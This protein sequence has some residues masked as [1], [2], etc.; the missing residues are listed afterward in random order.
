VLR[1]VV[2]PVCGCGDIFGDLA[3]G[4]FLDAV[5]EFVEVFGGGGNEGGGMF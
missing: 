2:V 4:E 3:A 5:A 1:K